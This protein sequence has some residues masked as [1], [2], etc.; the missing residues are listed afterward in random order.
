MFSELLL[1][2]QKR[3]LNLFRT[4]KNC[5]FIHRENKMKYEGS[6]R[7][8]SAEENSNFFLRQWNPSYSQLTVS[9]YKSYDNLLILA[10]FFSASSQRNNVLSS[11]KTG[12]LQSKKIFFC[13]QLSKL[14]TQYWYF[15]W[16]LARSNLQPPGLTQLA[17]FSCEFA[18]CHLKIVLLVSSAN[19]SINW[20]F[21]LAYCSV[22]G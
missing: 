3:N 19:S 9:S 18:L 7:W 17:H 2:F 20:N 21:N 15:E 5:Q 14:P 16:Q 11:L 10:K 22:H 8:C 4:R 6:M 1:A 12:D 13:G